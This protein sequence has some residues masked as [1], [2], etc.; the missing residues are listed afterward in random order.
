S[1]TACFVF[2]QVNFVVCQ[3]FALLT[4]FWFRLYLHP[5]KTSTFVRHVVATLLGFYLALFCFGWYALHFLIQSG[6]TYS[7]MIFSGVENMHKYC[8]V[9]ALGYLSFCQI[10]RVYV[11]DYGLYSADFTGPMM[12]ITQ[13]I[14]SLAFEIHD[15]MARR[16]EQ[17][18]PSQ[19]SLAVRRMPSLLE[20]LSYNCNFMGILAG[21]TCSYKDYISF[22][23]GTAYHQK[24]LEANGKE[25]G[26][27]KQSDPSPKTDVI[28]KLA[29]CAVSLL[30][31]LTVSRRFT[32]ERNVDDVFTASTPVYTQVLY[33]YLSMLATRPKYYFVWTLADAINNAAG[34]GFNGYNK[35]GSPRWD[36][37]SNLRIVDIEFATSFKMFLDNWNIQTALWLK[38]L[39][40][41]C[42]ERCPYNPTAA[43]F[44][45]SAMWHGVYPGYYIT[46][47]TGILMTLAARAYN[48]P[49]N[50]TKKHIIDFMD[51]YMFS[52]FKTQVVYIFTWPEFTIIML[53]LLLKLIDKSWYFCL[54]VACLLLVMVL[55]VKPRHKRNSHQENSLQQA[56]PQGR[57][58]VQNSHTATDNNC[59][60]KQK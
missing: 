16:G 14:T 20:Y 39:P 47:L 22:I 4:A 37:I 45:L 56:H 28:H 31:Y 34:F 40:R 11:F 24:H 9:A 60:Q 32:V 1:R 54:H 48:N 41:V 42:Y 46:F 44:I 7:M 49:S 30:V 55:P 5:S 3:L 29:V 43:T 23:E 51:I 36:L 52:I 2:P 12:I 38:S 21:P 50:R 8:F 25:N 17:L 15:G 57:P 27:Y 26:K 18:T 6:I 19:R 33:L 35:D 13:K 53:K 58:A 59:N 10:T